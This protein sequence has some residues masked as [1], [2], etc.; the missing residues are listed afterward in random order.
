[1]EQKILRYTCVVKGIFGRNRTVK[2][3]HHKLTESTPDSPIDLATL[4]PIWRTKLAE[5][6]FKRGLALLN[7]APITVEE[8]NIEGRVYRTECFW[9]FSQRTMHKER[10][11]DAA[12]VAAAVSGTEVMAW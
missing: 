7:E 10:F 11:E 5:I 9:A 1:M 4:L 8:L 12:A 3:A 2:F 6:G